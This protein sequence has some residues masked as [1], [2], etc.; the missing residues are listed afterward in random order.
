MIAPSGLDAT[1]LFADIGGSV[2]LYQEVGDAA[3]HQF[4]VESLDLMA[5]AI[6]A[7]R[8]VLLRTV[9][10]AAL[11]RFAHAD[12]ALRAAVA[13]QNAHHTSPLSVRVGFHAGPVIEDNGD[14][15]G[16][17]VNLAA[18][19]ASFARVNEITTSGGTVKALSTQYQRRAALLKAGSAVRG[20][21]DT[22]DIFRIDW[23]ST[24]D[25]SGQE[26]ATRI[27][28]RLVTSDDE[29]SAEFV[30]LLK[31]H[32]AG[33]VWEIGSNRTSLTFGRTELADVCVLSDRASRNHAH[34]DFRQGQFTLTDTSTNGTYV[35]KNAQP[36]FVVQRETVVLDGRGYLGIGVEPDDSEQQ[37]NL[38]TCQ[39][40]IDF[41]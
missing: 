24:T 23:Q 11:A 32:Y 7:E 28:T 33:Q 15:Y 6:K 40:S 39:F 20:M 27:A 10:D 31:V 16:H 30:Q 14:V 1:I 13:I 19:I 4:V 37:Q 8:G 25:Q 17:A 35:Q 5:Q 22:V 9:G 26:A 3:G 36:A 34:I 38:A 2:R 18:R 21:Q 41:G 29:P 12:E